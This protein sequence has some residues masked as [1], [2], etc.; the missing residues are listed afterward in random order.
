METPADPE[1]QHRAAGLEMSTAMKSSL[2]RARGRLAALIWHNSA[3]T[4]ERRARGERHTKRMSDPKELGSLDAS[5]LSEL[6][7]LKQIV[8]KT[9]V[10]LSDGLVA[11]GVDL[12]NK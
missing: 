2:G 8:Y 4:V 12:R 10:L 6:P 11:I 9:N 7:R 5:A 1:N 3:S